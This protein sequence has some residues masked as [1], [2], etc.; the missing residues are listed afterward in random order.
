MALFLSTK[1]MLSVIL[2]CYFWMNTQLK[3][4]SQAFLFII[5]LCLPLTLSA[6]PQQTTSKNEITFTAYNNL[7]ASVHRLVA[8]VP[9]ESYWYFQTSVLT[10]HFSP[11]PE[12]NNRQ[13]LLGFE[14]NRD[15]SYL[16]GAATFLNSFEQ[17]SYYAY[18]GK[19]FDFGSS[20]FYSKLSLGLIHGYKGEYRDKIPLNHLETA[21]AILPSIGIKI[22][23]F[24]S[25]LV[26]LGANAV[27]MTLGIGI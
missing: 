4:Y 25:D 24:Q 5:F 22:N 19:R 21:P 10:K 11:K 6:K 7:S 14:R 12:H 3:F 23:R 20:P 8:A 18:L 16:W 13:R 26:L 15:D 2:G 27:I 9:S 1:L 17:R